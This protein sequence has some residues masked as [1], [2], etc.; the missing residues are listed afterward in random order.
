MSKLIFIDRSR[1]LSIIA[2]TT[3]DRE[4]L[5]MCNNEKIYLLRFYSCILSIFYCFIIIF[6]FFQLCDYK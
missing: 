1:T 4:K 2:D 5:P 3:S 6:Y